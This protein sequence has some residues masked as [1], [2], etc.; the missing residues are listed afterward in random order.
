MS[1]A[2]M[3]GKSARAMAFAGALALAVALWVA[4]GQA[5]AE[6]APEPAIG[7]GVSTSAPD[8]Y[9]VIALLAESGIPM[10]ADALVV[11]VEQEY[12]QA[13]EVLDLVN[14]E[15]AKEGIRPLVMD[16][17]LLEAAMQRAVEISYYFS[18]ERPDGTDCWTVFPEG[19]ETVGENIA[20][21]Q[22]GPDW[23][24]NSWMNSSGHR[25]NILDPDF[26]TIGIGC[27][28][29]GEAGPYWV[30]CF[31]DGVAASFAR[32]S[33]RSLTVKCDVRTEWLKSENFEFRQT[34]YTTNVGADYAFQPEVRFIN[35]G[36]G[37]GNFVCE[38][39]PATFSWSSSK[40]S[41]FS[42][43]RNNGTIIGN[44][45]GSASVIASIGSMVRI[46]A[47]IVVEDESSQYGTWK[48]SGG[49]WWF[50]LDDG[51]YPY[52]QWA[53]IDGD[54]YHFDH[55]GYMQTGWLK[56]G[57]SWYYLKS[58]GPMAEGWQ[59]V[60]GAWYY[61]NPGSG[62]MATGWKQVGGTWY[63]LKGSGAMATGWQKVGGSWYYLKGSGAMAV[64]WQKA[65][66]TWYYLKGSGAMATGWRQIDGHWYFLSSSGAMVKNK[67]VGNYYLTGSGAMATN[68]WIGKYH[69]N[70]AGKWD[71]TR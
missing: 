43:D 45:P 26:T 6:E 38:L 71:Q 20:M 51:S 2:R 29:V 22:P 61:L 28:Y 69:V 12:G 16:R 66:A 59:K 62:A 34:G 9:G 31:G 25:A 46:E 24:M 52:S 18:H 13:Y 4:P 32:P 11:D 35:Q 64:G 70:A 63:Y 36:D 10:T 5:L 17:G 47:P 33:D 27:V 48:K 49:K 42:V 50:Q 44:A 65:G 58:S 1:C 41:V 15:R 14:A 21:M 7:V 57:K 39:D 53:Q 23:V 67:W 8:E 55:S 30:Q 37:S 19:K 3:R 40:P 68:T 56:L 60:G 54:W